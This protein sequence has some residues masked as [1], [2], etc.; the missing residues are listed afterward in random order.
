MCDLSL[1]LNFTTWIKENFGLFDYENLEEIVEKDINMKKLENG[2][3]FFYRYDENIFH[4]FV[5]SKYIDNKK[6]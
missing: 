2:E 5:K 3:Y 6:Q 1:R 4:Y